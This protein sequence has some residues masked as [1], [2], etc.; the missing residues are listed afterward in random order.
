MPALRQALKESGKIGLGKVVLRDREDFVAI[1]PH[2]E[3][4]VVYKLHYPKEIRKLNEVPEL[5]RQQAV[6][7]STTSSL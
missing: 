3:G 7:Q 1:A 6:A 5:D 2:E 4:I